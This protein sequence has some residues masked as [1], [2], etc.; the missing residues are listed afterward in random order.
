[1]AAAVSIER[2]LGPSAAVW[3]V[4]L[5]VSF[6][7]AVVTVT[8]DAGTQTASTMALSAATHI[9]AQV[10]FGIV[11]AAVLTRRGL[12]LGTVAGAFA[13]VVD[14]PGGILAGDVA[15]ERGACPGHHRGRA[16]L[17]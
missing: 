16:R 15:G 17:G 3:V 12:A 8:L 5:P 1:M 14:V 2:R 13:Y 11:F 4:A 6:S 7:V 9:P 10:V